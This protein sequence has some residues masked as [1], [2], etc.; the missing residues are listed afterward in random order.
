MTKKNNDNINDEISKYYSL[1][2]RYD[3]NKNKNKC[4]K[5]KSHSGSI[6]KINLINGTRQLIAKC[7]DRNNPCELNIVINMKQYILLPTLI[8]ELQCKL[9]DNEV[10]IIKYKNNQIFDLSTTEEVLPQ[11]NKLI[12]EHTHINNTYSKLLI[13]YNTIVHNPDKLEKIKT[14]QNEINDNIQT[15]NDLIMTYNAGT[16]SSIIVLDNIMTNYSTLLS[17]IDTYNSLNY[18][19]RIVDVFDDKTKHLVAQ[20][21]IPEM[22]EYDNIK[23][24]KDIVVAS[25]PVMIDN[26]I[27]IRGLYYSD[28]NNNNNNNTWNK[29]M[30]KF[31]TKVP[32]FSNKTDAD[33]F[34]SQYLMSKSNPYKPVFTHSITM[35][36]DW[37]QIKIYILNKHK[38]LDKSVVNVKENKLDPRVYN[39]FQSRLDWNIFKNRHDKS[40]M[41]NTLK[42]LFYHMRCGI[43]VMIKGGKVGIFAPFANEKYTNNWKEVFKTLP[44]ETRGKLLRPDSTIYSRKKYVKEK[45]ALYGEE[46]RIPLNKWWANGNILDNVLSDQVWGDHFL[47]Q[48]KDMFAEMCKNREVPDCQF[49]INKRDYPQLKIHNSKSSTEFPKLKQGD[50]VEPYGF[51]FNRDDRLPEENIPLSRYGDRTTAF[52]PILS[53]YTSDHFADLSIPSTEDWESATK[54]VFPNAKNSRDLFSETSEHVEWEKKKKIAFFRGTATGGGTT[55]ENNQRLKIAQL[56]FEWN[57]NKD[58]DILDAKLTGW[59]PRDK[60]IASSDLTYIR[61]T[62]YDFIVNKKKNF[63]PIYE[64]NTYKYLLYIEGHCAACRYG[65]MMGMDCVILKVDSTVVADKLWYFSVLKGVDTSS[66]STDYKECDHVPVKS[67]LSNLREQIEWC[68]NNDDKCKQISKNAS[69]LY[70]IYI[71]KE[72]IMDYLQNMCIS[73][74]NR[75]TDQPIVKTTK[76]KKKRTD[77][78]KGRKTKET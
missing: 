38:E 40:A 11:F 66:N 36:S 1:K 33:K 7:G 37:D 50:P 72:G 55:P 19:K 69:K 52:C 43:Y 39:E 54:R 76:I 14:V 22:L 48:L 9:N 15:H 46:D 18:A 60:K 29:L 61:K 45:E 20:K 53:F 25:M 65:A 75:P 31:D 51:I 17:N 24:E 4:I 32:H 63:V 74:A 12:D 27:M 42:Y 67:D 2:Q 3:N 30:E 13:Q 70:N 77:G 10:N 62:N 57:N 6:F 71:S 34:A 35:L 23:K 44:E 26:T 73:I 68:K 59:N 49:F 16:T 56:C 78:T 64:Q 58:N 5:C 41:E 21:I 8:E 47:F 28:N